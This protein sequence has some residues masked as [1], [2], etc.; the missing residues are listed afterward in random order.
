MP[1]LIQLLIAFLLALLGKQEK[2]GP[3]K[4]PYNFSTVKSDKSSLPDI[5][6]FAARDGKQLEYRHYSFESN[7]VIVILHGSG[8]H[9]EYLQP[10]ADNLRTNSRA[11]IITPN[12]RGHGINPC[13]RGDILYAN[14][15]IDDLNDL[16]LFIKSKIPMA[17]I[18]LG[19]HSS[20]GGLAIRYA[21]SKY[22]ND[23]N[24]Y[25]FLA[26]YLKYNAPSTKKNSG[27]WVHVHTPRIIGLSILNF[28]RIKLF[29]HLKTI[30]FNMPHTVRNGTETLSYSYRLMVGYAPNHYKNDL[31]KIFQPAFLGVGLEDESF[32]A[33][34]YPQ[35]VQK[36]NNI[37]ITFIENCSHLELVSNNELFEKLNKWLALSI[38][39]S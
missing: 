29:N 3:N 18:I 36:V 37:K 4:S 32:N 22:N 33:K 17:K 20:G 31:K 7:I 2:T 6:Q 1:V 9:S 8:W 28:Y 38:P 25:F 27:G 5:K 23:I 30:E 24:G 15:L 21:G 14:Q 11:H 35:E 13:N 34:E 10:L 12:L 16:I 19:G 26:P 39:S